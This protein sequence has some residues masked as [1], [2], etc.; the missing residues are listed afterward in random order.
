MGTRSHGTAA[1]RRR[2]A[3]RKRGHAVTVKVVGSHTR[4]PKLLAYIRTIRSELEDRCLRI[5]RELEKIKLNAA[6][7]E[8]SNAIGRLTGMRKHG[9]WLGAKTAADYINGACDSLEQAREEASKWGD[10]ACAFEQTLV[11]LRSIAKP[12]RADV[13]SSARP[14]WTSVNTL[15]DRVLEETE[16]LDE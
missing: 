11:R 5:E 15:I 12:A 16:D 10:E 13:T 2:T 8:L 1:A 4:H 7:P 9:E 6:D 14:S 3:A